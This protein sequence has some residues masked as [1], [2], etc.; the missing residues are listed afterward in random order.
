MDIDFS[1]PPWPMNQT[2]PV[3][4]AVRHLTSHPDHQE[5]VLEDLAP[6]LSAVEQASTDV[7]A[8]WAGIS[9]TGGQDPVS[10][11]VVAAVVLRAVSSALETAAYA[12][13]AAHNLAHP[14]EAVS[15]EEMRAQLAR[16]DAEALEQAING[17][18]A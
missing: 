13:S 12:R 3:E 14:Q 1:P 16:Q 11:Q 10:E 5:Q 8:V 7:M 2:A 15:E 9:R 17:G 4:A 6:V 18:A